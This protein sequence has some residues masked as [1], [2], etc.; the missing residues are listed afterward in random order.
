MRVVKVQDTATA[1][2]APA[3]SI[4]VATWRNGGLEGI[5]NYT[6]L[7]PF[8]SLMWTE[9]AFR[10]QA[11]TTGGGG[12][13]QG[14]MQIFCN[15][16]LLI[17]MQSNGFQL[18][19]PGTGIGFDFNG[20]DIQTPTHWVS[21]GTDDAFLAIDLNGNGAIDS[22]RE[23]FG[24]STRLLDQP[25][26]SATDGF[27]AFAQYDLIENGG[28]GNGRINRK[29][30]VWGDLL[31]WNDANGNGV[32]EED[33][34]TKVSDSELRAMKLKPRHDED[35]I[36]INGSLL[37]DWTWVRTR[38]SSNLPPRLRMVDVYFTQ[39]DAS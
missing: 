24:D 7:S 21:D 31:L 22:G 27:E 20:D 6:K 11:Q 33:E 14:G 35:G 32:S 13:F 9:N 17:D 36:D 26:E 30:G 37:Q 16:P 10:V 2:A 38:K 3:R 1:T 23:L 28:D 18:T 29:D 15:T 8:A 5:G 39:L 19:D 25:Q 4:L 34:I 12:C